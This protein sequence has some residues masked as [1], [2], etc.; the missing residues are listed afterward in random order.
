[1]EKH[2]KPRKPGSGRP[3]GATS[4]IKVDASLLKD[5]PDGMQILVNRRQIQMLSESLGGVF[6]EIMAKSQK[7]PIDTKLVKDLAQP[8]AE[9]KEIDLS[10][11]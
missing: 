4:C 8:I 7:T 10:T 1:M 6:K 2:K 9:I 5:L 3:S 11:L